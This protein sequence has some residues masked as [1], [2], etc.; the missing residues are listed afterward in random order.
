MNPTPLSSYTTQLQITIHATPAKVWKAMTKDVSKWWP[1][2]YHS[3]EETK[4]F[5]MEPKVGGRIYE[6]EGD[7]AGAE[8]GRI[9]VF[10]PDQKLVWTGDHFGSF[11]NNWGRFYLTLQLVKNHQGTTIE[12]EDSGYGMLDPGTP[13]SLKAGWQE[14]YGQHLKQY[15]EK[16]TKR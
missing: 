7:G 1:S 16:K 6:D 3:S 9:I 5:V 13:A 11:G 14:L 4:T 15:V 2:H 8:W 10:Q 12:I